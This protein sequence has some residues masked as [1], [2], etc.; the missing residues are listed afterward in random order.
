M[1]T[2]PVTV[3]PVTGTVVGVTPTVGV[4]VGARVWVGAG[5]T[6]VSVTA[7]RVT[8]SDVGVTTSMLNAPQAE[9]RLSVKTAREVIQS[10][11]EK[12]SFM[13]YVSFMTESIE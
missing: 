7:G 2:A 3:G 9:R 11:R 1:V 6:G 4:S 12:I 8:G 5:V 13:A 10:L